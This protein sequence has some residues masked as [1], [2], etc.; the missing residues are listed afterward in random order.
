[1]HDIITHT[2]ENGIQSLPGY[3][4]NS[5]IES[6]EWIRMFVD[7]GR[8]VA[9]YE[10]GSNDEQDDVRRIV[11]SEE[12][13]ISMAKYLYQS[14]PFDFANNL[15]LCLDKLINKSNLDEDN[16]KR[17]K[18]HFL[19]IIMDEIKDK[20]PDVYQKNM[21]QSVHDDMSVYGNNS[22]VKYD[23]DDIY[24]LINGAVDDISLIKREVIKEHAF[25]NG[26]NTNIPVYSAQKIKWILSRSKGWV[27]EYSKDELLELAAAWR[28]EREEY[29]GWIV[30]PFN[31]SREL[32]WKTPD[33][34]GKALDDMELT[35]KLVLLYEYVWRNETGMLS[36]SRN[37]QQKVYSVWME[38]Y[39]WLHENDID[40]HLSEWFFMGRALLREFREDRNGYEWNNVWNKLFEYAQNDMIRYGKITLAVEKVKYEFSVYNMTEVRSLMHHLSIPDECYELRICRIGMH[41]ECGSADYAKN[42]AESLLQ[43]IHN[44]FKE[45]GVMKNEMSRQHHQTQEIVRLKSLYGIVLNMESFIVEGM[46]FQRGEY[47]Q[48]RTL[49]N[50]I[51]AQI[52]I[53]RDY[54]DLFRMENYVNEALLKWQTGLYI[55]NEPVEINREL[56]SFSYGKTYCEE[57]YFLYRLIDRIQFPVMFDR[58]HYFGNIEKPWLSALYDAFPQIALN[59]IVRSAKSDNAKC[60][61][62]RRRLASFGREQVK[63][64]IRYL[65]NLIEF[66]L[67][68]F[69]EKHVDMD[70]SVCSQLKSNIPEILVRYMTRCPEGMQKD[71]L[72]ILIK[73]MEAPDIIMDQRMD[74]F[75]VNI[76]R[77]VSDK[78]K[79]EMLE[80]M[81]ETEI[82]EHEV[83]GGHRN[84]FDFFDCYFTHDDAKNYCK[85]TDRLKFA[86]N[87]LL[88]NNSDDDIYTWRTKNVR[89]RVLYSADML[90][91]D[92][93]ERYIDRL[94][95][96]LNEDTKLPDL[97]NWYVW[98][99]FELIKEDEQLPVV[100]LKA[101]VLKHGMMQRFGNEING[102]HISMG[103][104]DYLEQISMMARQLK[105]DFF[106]ID[107][108]ERIFADAIDYWDFSKDKM[109]SY[110]GKNNRDMYDEYVSRI[111]SVLSM[112]ENVY[113]N[114][115]DKLSEKISVR[116]SD[117]LNDLEKY[118]IYA[119]VLGVL[120]QTGEQLQKVVRRIKR[121]VFSSDDRQSV[122]AMSAVFNY[123][124]EYPENEIAKELFECLACV[125]RT[126]KEPCLVSCLVLVHNLVYMDSLVVNEFVEDLDASLHDLYYGTEYDWKDNDSTTKHKVF[127]RSACARLAHQLKKK[128]PDK[129]GEGEGLW[130]KLGDSDDFA[131][132][133]N[134]VGR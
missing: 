23:L 35:E 131:E 56:R 109:K 115:T 41:M 119:D 90:T 91:A 43:Y 63:E 88:D 60:I 94:W 11:F 21:I 27:Y 122:D 123:I 69:E 95:S 8:I 112:L 72:R 120:F 37:T 59:L 124:S 53:Y 30:V 99:F 10:N 71:V 15:K 9:N 12:T 24:D 14:S 82:V 67:D 36:Y 106:T 74:A 32:S 129:V 80:E 77:L 104:I 5:H 108:V 128:Y 85:R 65:C 29:P 48:K 76:M 50:Q 44:R 133:R 25:S 81:L 51:S 100:S 13:M 113:Q 111:Y 79:A 61:L 28:K 47:E 110:I 134:E 46:A 83:L 22:I 52:D 33:Y 75:V 34:F 93:K 57:A 86:I 118:D 26:S 126:R 107:E 78:V 125:L 17:C 54:F 92:E 64:D 7:A 39:A 98:N 114:V 87:A 66:N 121:G 130:M 18:E 132:V 49:I 4:F 42:E 31:V 19:S 127:V 70:H 105:P 73:L 2:I 55:K 89:L 16:R 103:E 58:V 101:N 116:I 20:F 68:E 6:T 1:M 40:N 102:V 38:Y 62:T 96:R 3:L 97:P 45:L 117:F 84:S